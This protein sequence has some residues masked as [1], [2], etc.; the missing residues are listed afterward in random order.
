MNGAN[1]TFRAVTDPRP[2]RPPTRV[3]AWLL[4][5]PVGHAVAGFS[6]WLVLLSRYVWARV[7]GRRPW[8]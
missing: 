5:G 2:L 7:R 1:D 3:A 6:D 8:A 4:T